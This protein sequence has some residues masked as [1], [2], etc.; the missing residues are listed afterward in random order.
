MTAP[1]PSR[2]TR[3][4]LLGM[5]A[6]AGATACSVKA[7]N[8]LPPGETA[9]PRA[10]ATRSPQPEVTANAQPTRFEPLADDSYPNAKRLAGRFVQAL[11][12]YDD[13]AKHR[14]VVRAA[15]RN[16]DR[17]FAVEAALRETSVMFHRGAAS[18]G[19]IVYP[20]LGGLTLGSGDDRIC[21]MVVVRQSLQT[22]D[23]DRTEVRTVDVRLINRDNEWQLE[24]IVNAGGTPVPRNDK[25][26]STRARTVLDD[27]RIELPD[28]AR[29]DI[30]AGRVD[31][32]L[33]ASMAGMAEQAPYSVAVL[34]TGHPR[35]VFG[36]D[37]ISGHTEGRAV[38]IWK[39][40]GIPVVQ[41]QPSKRSEAHEFSEWLL[42]EEFIPEL[43]SPWDLDGPPEPGKVKPSFTD[44]VHADHI[45]VAYKA[46]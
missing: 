46:V 21:V 13:G 8:P 9:V 30:H 24:Q 15:A 1:E 11:T 12:T 2:I 40:D 36:T 6:A 29:W 3:R 45:H 7:G 23:G 5:L 27:A 16:A 26:L 32:R 37:L 18:R 31:D 39:I 22:D 38:D 41:Q 44:A 10:P 35:N 4:A 34:K 17:D 42:N 28:S 33:L 19:E 25:R 20:Q 43:G 14:D